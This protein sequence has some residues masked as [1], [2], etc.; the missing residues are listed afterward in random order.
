MDRDRIVDVAHAHA[1]GGLAAPRHNP[2]P[3]QL[4]VQAT[5]QGHLILPIFALD[6]CVRYATHQRARELLLIRV[7]AVEPLMPPNLS[8]LSSSSIRHP[9]ALPSIECNK[10]IPMINIHILPEH[11][12]GSD[13]NRAWQKWT[14]MQIQQETCST[15][16][17]MNMIYYREV[18]QLYLYWVEQ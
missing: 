1:C 9:A 18:L 4:F 14:Q 13:Q 6:T 17:S 12:E 10:F 5:D 15:S 16:M 8:H 3:I 2:G 7:E 11:F